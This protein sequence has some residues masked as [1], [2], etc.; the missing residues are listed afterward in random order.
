MERPKIGSHIAL[1]NVM[2]TYHEIAHT[3]GWLSHSTCPF[4]T[5]TVE[6]LQLISSACK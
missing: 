2:N 1:E 6:L 4:M 3:E 5:D